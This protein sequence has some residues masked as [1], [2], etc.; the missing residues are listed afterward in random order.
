LGERLVR[1]EEVD[2]SILFGSTNFL[3]PA[4]RVIVAPSACI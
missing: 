3:S 4:L 1:N 2:S